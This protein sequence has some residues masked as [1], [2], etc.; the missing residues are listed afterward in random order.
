[1]DIHSAT[2]QV[3]VEAAG[4]WPSIVVL[5]SDNRLFVLLYHRM[6][7]E[8]R[9][10]TVGGR[11][12][13]FEDMKSLNSFIEGPHT[14]VPNDVHL[15]LEVLSS[16]T[17]DGLSAEHFPRNLVEQSIFWIAGGRML[18]GTGQVQRLLETLAFLK[19]WHDSLQ[20]EGMVGRWPDSLDDASQILT[21]V[22]V[23][24]QITTL[25]AAERLETRKLRPVLAGEVEDLL[26]WSA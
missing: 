12:C 2:W 10:L 13:A 8:D 16:L 9:V 6:D 15:A 23:T 24:H 19:D 17:P 14:G 4:I 18:S 11:T 25:E 21:D 7:G 26:R 20:E 3:A 1:M 5:G 22:V